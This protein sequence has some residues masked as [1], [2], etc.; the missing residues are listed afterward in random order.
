MPIEERFGVETLFLVVR[1]FDYLNYSA[2]I[3]DA[4]DRVWFRYKPKLIELDMK[5]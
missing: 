1:N 4:L 2:A 5:N 3:V